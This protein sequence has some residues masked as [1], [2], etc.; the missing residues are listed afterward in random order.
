MI[1]MFLLRSLSLTCSWSLVWY[2]LPSLYGH[3][4]PG[5]LFGF[6]N[7]KIHSAFQDRFQFPSVLASRPIRSRRGQMGGPWYGRQTRFRSSEAK[8]EDWVDTAVVQNGGLKDRQS[9]NIAL[10]RTETIDLRSLLT[11][12]QPGPYNGTDNKAKKKNYRQE[13]K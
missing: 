12:P 4:Q 8:N 10:M 1:S 6:G 2:P 3:L 9:I 11:Q 5:C 13:S 7:H